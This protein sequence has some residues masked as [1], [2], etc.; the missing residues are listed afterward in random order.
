MYQSLASLFHDGVRPTFEQYVLATSLRTIGDGSLLRPARAAIEILYH[1]GE[2]YKAEKDPA[3][4]PIHIEA[5]CPGHKLLRNFVDA[6]KHHTINQNK[7]EISRAF[8]L[9]E[10]LRIT[11]FRDTQGL[12]MNN[13]ILAI[14]TLDNG[15]EVDLLSVM[16]RVINFWGKQL[17][18]DGLLPSRYSHIYTGETVVPR[19]MVLPPIEVKGTVGIPISI[20]LIGRQYDYKTKE[21]KDVKFV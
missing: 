16:V 7:P 12:Y 6:A 21:F 19:N 3:F 18:D 17:F 4:T 15:N 9:S 14:A 1:F 20:K 2:H 11:T 13:E 5:L 8:Q 10:A